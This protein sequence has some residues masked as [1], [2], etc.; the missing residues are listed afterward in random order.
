MKI[1]EVAAKLDVSVD[2]LRYYE[3]IGLIRQV[4]RS[5]G[6]RNYSNT[7]IIWL[8]FIQRLKETGMPLQEIERYAHLRYAGDRT[9]PE[10]KT[11]LQKHRKSLLK[12]LEKLQE[13]L[14]ALD[15]KIKIYKEKEEKHESLSSRAEKAH[16]D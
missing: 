9:I 15:V 7:D 10:R 5:S 1:G 16:R 6:K 14:K 4:A 13:N 2:T 11:M 3:K 8:E 12:K